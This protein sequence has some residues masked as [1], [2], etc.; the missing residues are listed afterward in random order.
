MK[1]A[2]PAIVALL[3]LGLVGCSATDPHP[4]HIATLVSEPAYLS[5]VGLAGTLEITESGCWGFGGIP[6]LFPEGTTIKPDGSGISFSNGESLDLG[7]QLETS[8]SAIDPVTVQAHIPPEC[9]AAEMLLLV[10]IDTQN[11]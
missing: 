3:A 10:N 9:E 11:S 8:G 4:S 1:N 7:S 5:A 2:A 6:G